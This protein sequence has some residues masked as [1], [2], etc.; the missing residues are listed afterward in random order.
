MNNLNEIDQ[1]ANKLASLATL[2]RSTHS[3][4]QIEQANQVVRQYHSVMKQL[5]DLGWR[6]DDLL[7]DAELPNQLMPNFYISH[8]DIK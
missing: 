5:W 3:R 7:P 2:W 1:L 8:W 6:G 4:Q